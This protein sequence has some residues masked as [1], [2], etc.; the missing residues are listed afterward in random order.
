MKALQQLRESYSAD[1]I[2]TPEKAKAYLAA[3]TRNRSLNAATVARYK[4]L[5][6]RGEF[7]HGVACISFDTTGTLI[8]GQHRLSA[9]VA[10]GQPVKMIVVRGMDPAA[11]AAI[12]TGRKRSASDWLGIL[13]H[14]NTRVLAATVRLIATYYADPCW[15]IWTKPL[16]M[17]GR[18]S[19]HRTVDSG[20]SRAQLAY[21]V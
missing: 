8:D 20:I 2:I 14:K 17:A 6:E 3:N 1:E 11:Q 10:A 13:G 12:D 19:R 21:D 5:I 15:H 7:F 16:A 18:I 4:R 9:V